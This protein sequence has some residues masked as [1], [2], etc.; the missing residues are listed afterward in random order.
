MFPTAVHT[1]LRLFYIRSYIPG[2]DNNNA[3][4]LRGMY[5]PSEK[6]ATDLDDCYL[7]RNL[8]FSDP[9]KLAFKPHSCDISSEY[10]LTLRAI[11]ISSHPISIHILHIRLE[12]FVA[13]YAA[14]KIPLMKQFSCMSLIS[15]FPKITSSSHKVLKSNDPQ[16]R[17]VFWK[18]AWF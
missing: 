4:R 15:F 6:D 11:S 16:G 12:L 18:C 17:G 5:F 13:I 8:Y 1:L 10:A 3:V 9:L 7:G 14:F 2:N